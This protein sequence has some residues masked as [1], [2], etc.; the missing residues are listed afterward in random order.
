MILFFK[1]ILKKL[2]PSS[3]RRKLKRIKRCVKR[4]LHPVKK[5]SIVEMDALL[6]KSLGIKE[7]DKIIVFS[8][9][10]NLNA[11]FSPADL[12]KLLMKIVGPEGL[13]MMPYYPPLNSTEWAANNETFDMRNTK[14]GMGVLTNVFASMPDVYMSKHP[15]KAVCAWG[16]D[17]KSIVEGHEKSTT[18]F[19]FDSPYGKLLK[20]HSKSLGLGVKNIATMHAIED[21]LT[22]PHDFYYQKNKYNLSLIDKAGVKTTVE[23]LVHDE[24]IMN[25]CELPGDYVYSLDCKSYKRINVGYKYVYVI[26]NDDL[27]STCEEHFK[28]GHTR[29]KK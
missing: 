18:P 17:A 24:N 4:K 25:K 28:K 22:T 10:G 5:M 20:L 26:D 16:K 15:T 2:I 14:S 27:M 7:G 3:R 9:F 21:I 1:K 12:V 13:I 6:T 23:V 29:Q 8:S 19:Y 11:D